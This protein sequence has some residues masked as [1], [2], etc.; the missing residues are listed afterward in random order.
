M[1]RTL[2]MTHLAYS[3]GFRG[4]PIYCQRLRRLARQLDQRRRGSKSRPGR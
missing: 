1:S 3:Y 2:R 4:H